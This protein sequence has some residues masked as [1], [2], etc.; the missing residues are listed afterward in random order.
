MMPTSDPFMT[1]R[2]RH[3]S[4]TMRSDS[5]RRILDGGAGDLRELSATY[6]NIIQS[7]LKASTKEMS[8]ITHDVNRPLL[9]SHC[10]FPFKLIATAMALTPAS[11]SDLHMQLHV[12]SDLIDRA[13]VCVDDF[14]NG[15]SVQHESVADLEAYL[16]EH[17]AQPLIAAT[18]VQ[19]PSVLPT[20]R[21]ARVRNMPLY[22]TRNALHNTSLKQTVGLAKQAAWISDMTAK[23]VMEQGRTRR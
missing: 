11:V 12:A 14:V 18:R 4:A 8:R 3:V 23:N 6:N 13:C 15:G 7:L 9:K 20:P 2:L 17:D 10:K 22:E 16:Y 21:S 1:S 5:V 19:E